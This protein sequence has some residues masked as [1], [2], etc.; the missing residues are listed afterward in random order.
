MRNKETI[1]S[2]IAH[3]ALALETVVKGNI[4][5]EEDLRIDG[6]IE[7]DIECSGRVIIG[8]Q[9]EVNGGIKC[10]NCDL[11]GKVEGNIYTGDTVRL[12]A[13]AYLNGDLTTKFIEIEIGA[14][15]NG[16][17]RIVNGKP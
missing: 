9:A 17:C 3:N 4:K 16:S 13:S 6:K 14:M 7:G 1:T 15:F 8:Q 2:G 10:E 11:Y 5:A 12:R